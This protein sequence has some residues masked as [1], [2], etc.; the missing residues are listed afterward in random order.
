VL[1]ELR[2]Q[3]AGGEGRRIDRRLE[4]RP[5][6]DDGADVVLVGMRDDDA[7]KVGAVLL[8]ET[9][10]WEDDVDAGVVLALGEGDAAID[11]QPAALILRPETVEIGVHA[12]LAQ[13]AKCQEHEFVAAST[14]AGC[15][16]LLAHASSSFA[17]SVTS[18]KEKLSWRP[19][20]SSSSSAPV[21]SSPAKVPETGPPAALTVSASP[22]APARARHAARTCAK[23]LPPSQIRIQSFMV[24]ARKHNASRGESDN[25]WRARNV[26]V[27]PRSSGAE[28][29]LRPTPITAT[30]PGGG[31]RE[32]LSTRMPPVFAVPTRMSLG[33]LRRSPG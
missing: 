28:T 8:D 27:L 31:G 32:V 15:T 20:A 30:K 29:R 12:D 9:H 26:A 10:I 1:R 3:H 5:Q 25:P 6:L 23:P 18:P 16:L 22:I 2:L 19:S 17:A 4:A 13:T 24:C 21:S 7:G 11:H 33:H 14:A